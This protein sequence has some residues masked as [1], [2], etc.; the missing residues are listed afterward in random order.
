VPVVD[1]EAATVWAAEREVVAA[2]RG[3][4]ATD[5]VA[6]AF[7]GA[8]AGTADRVVTALAGAL[9][10]RAPEADSPFLLAGLDG[11]VVAALA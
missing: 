8:V 7:A 9:A 4:P 11:F 6:A 3:C 2:C 10:F 5:L 1:R